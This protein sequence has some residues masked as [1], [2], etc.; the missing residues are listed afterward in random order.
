MLKLSAS[1]HSPKNRN[2]SLFIYVFPQGEDFMAAIWIL[3]KGGAS[4]SSEWSAGPNPAFLM[5]PSPAK[6]EPRK[7]ARPAAAARARA[8]AL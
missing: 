6:E 3:Q 5:W 2:L 8:R 7:V 1:D 4:E